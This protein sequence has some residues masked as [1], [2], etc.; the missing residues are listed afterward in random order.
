MFRRQEF[1]NAVNGRRQSEASD[2]GI[3]EIAEIW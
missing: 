3:L 1:S 2:V